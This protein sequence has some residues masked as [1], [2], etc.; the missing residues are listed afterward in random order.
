[1]K[2]LFICLTQY[3]VK[4]LMAC[5]RLFEEEQ[6]MV[7]ACLLKEFSDFLKVNHIKKFE[8]NGEKFQL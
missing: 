7:E 6:S 4:Y 8:F 3:Q 1:M 2:E 5:M